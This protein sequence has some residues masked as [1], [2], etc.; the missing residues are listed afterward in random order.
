MTVRPAV[1]NA[2][3]RLPVMGFQGLRAVSTPVGFHH[4][5]G[6]DPIA[7]LLVTPRNARVL[8]VNIVNLVGP[9]RLAA[10]ADGVAVPARFDMTHGVQKLGSVVKRTKYSELDRNG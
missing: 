6:V 4:P 9:D 5:L 1:V 7:A 8:P 3:Q 2:G 10:V